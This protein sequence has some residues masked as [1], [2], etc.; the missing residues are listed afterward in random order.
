VILYMVNI[1]SSQIRVF[2]RNCDFVYGKYFG[3]SLLSI[4]LSGNMRADRFD[5]LN[6]RVERWLVFD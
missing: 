2:E 5:W 4:K 6:W 3:V 1:S